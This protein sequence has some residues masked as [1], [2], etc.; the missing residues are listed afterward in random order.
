MKTRLVWIYTLEAKEW[1][2]NC[3]LDLL[4]DNKSPKLIELKCSGLDLDLYLVCIN[5]DIGTYL[6]P[7]ISRRNESMDLL[8]DVSRATVDS[9]L[10]TTTQFFRRLPSAPAE[11][12]YISFF[13]IG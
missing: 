6:T 4:L 13:L 7:F 11:A 1:K 5:F 8:S 12:F 3:A 2:A 10:S 9:H